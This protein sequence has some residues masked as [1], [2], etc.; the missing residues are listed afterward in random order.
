M[1]V[2]VE[3][4]LAAVKIT[5]VGLA[6]LYNTQP[7]KEA[8]NGM[9]RSS[10][11]AGVPFR[12]KFT[13]H[14]WDVQTERAMRG[15]FFNMEGD[16]ALVRIRIPDVTAIDGPFASATKE[17]RDNNRLGIPFETGATYATGVGHALPTLETVLTAAATMPTREVYVASDTEL[18]GGCAISINEFCYGIAGSWLEDGVNRLKLSPPLRQDLAAGD[19]VSL[20]P[21][22]VGTCVTDSPGY[23][24]LVKGRFGEHTLEF[25]EDLTRL[26][27]DID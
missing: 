4:P 19:V 8:T 9:R 14:V 16:H 13:A 3:F 20:A 10:G 1:A 22:F 27:E 18:P 21:V 24:E 2:Y 5:D 26:V 12:L 11:M 7:G 23:Q 17:V 25:I 15:F 6:P